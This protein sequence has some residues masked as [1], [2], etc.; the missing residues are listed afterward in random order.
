MI[1]SGPAIPS[2]DQGSFVE[3]NGFIYINERFKGIHVFDNSNLGNPIKVYFW[4]IPGNSE[5]TVDGNFLYADNS[6]HFITIDIS[7][8]ANIKV[9]SHVKDLFSNGMENE[10]Y[11]KNYRGVFECVE[12]EKGIVVGWENQLLDSPKCR[13][14]F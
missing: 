5:F 12:F 6:R 9:L 11:P 13:T 1:F 4:H 8:P 3:N 2:I 7:D 14:V 10:N